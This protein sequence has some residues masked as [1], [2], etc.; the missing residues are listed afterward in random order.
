MKIVAADA[1]ARTLSEDEVVALFAAPNVMHLGFVDGKGWPVV[2]P[3]WFVYEYDV[4]RIAVGRTSHKARML[5]AN[6]RAYFCI[7]TAT[8]EDT[9]GVRGRA[10]VMMFEGDRDLAVNVA[11]KAL[12][13]YTGTDTDEYAQQ[14]LGWA[15]DGEMTVVELSTGEFRAF[16]Y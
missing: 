7:D 2:N 12:L 5:R 10:R 4:F 3:V 15:R 13:K 14:M 6:P 11:R 8:A 9:R 1:K 16:Q